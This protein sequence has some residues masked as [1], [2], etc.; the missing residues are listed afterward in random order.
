MEI[1]EG[2]ITVIGPTSMTINVPYNNVQ[3]ACLRQYDEV[4]VG[5]P[6]GRKISPE[7]RRKAY[8]LMA[9]IAE[10]CG[11]T[12]DYI[13]RHMKMD[14]IVNHLQAMEKQLFSLSDCDVTT[15]REFISHLIDFCV[16]HWVPCRFPIYEQCEDIERYVNA[17]LMHKRCVVCGEKADLHHVEAIGMGRDRTTVYQIGMPVMPL[18]RIHHGEAHSKGM[19]W[20]LDDLHLVPIP[21]NEEIGKAYRLTKKNMIKEAL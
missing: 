21:L 13:K 15:A 9:E 3:R 11:H 1:V 2:K 18:C 17:C 19:G 4:Q 5:L 8:A 12:P 16:E 6:D 10:W 7:Q 14:F 20:L